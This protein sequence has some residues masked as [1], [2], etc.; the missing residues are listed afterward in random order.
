M[1]QIGVVE[2]NEKTE[3]TSDNGYEIET[4]KVNLKTK[5]IREVNLLER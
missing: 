4:I 3:S 1:I 5:K 2:D